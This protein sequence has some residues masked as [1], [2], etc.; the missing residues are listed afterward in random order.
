[1]RKI[2]GI[3]WRFIYRIG[4]DAEVKNVRNMNGIESK[5]TEM[6]QKKKIIT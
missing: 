1:M 2:L 3:F 6:W 5:E 4:V